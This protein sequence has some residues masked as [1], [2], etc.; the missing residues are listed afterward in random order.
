MCVSVCVCVYGCNTEH[1]LDLRRAAYSAARMP[2]AANRKPVR[3]AVLAHGRL[4]RAPRGS[5]ER[6]VRILKWRYDP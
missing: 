2:R 5:E 4:R 1:T 3:Q 6:R